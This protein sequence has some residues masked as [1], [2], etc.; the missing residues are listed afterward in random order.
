MMKNIVGR[1][2][3]CVAGNK[4]C[5]SSR[6]GKEIAVHENSH[7]LDYKKIKE[8]SVSQFCIII[9]YWHVF[10]VM[11]FFKD[12]LQPSFASDFKRILNYC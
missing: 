7:D 6:S 1:A 4:L 9:Y 8:F 5:I 2:P 12:N 3:I 10:P 11:R